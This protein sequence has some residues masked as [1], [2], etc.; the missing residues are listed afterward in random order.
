MARNATGRGA[1]T[2]AQQRYALGAR[3]WRSKIRRIL[4]A[5]LGPFIL[6][7]IAALV[8]YGH[9]LAW[10]G[11]A[12]AGACAATWAAL[13]E[14]PPAYIENW[15]RGAEGE[16]KTAGVV[17]P[18]ERYGLTVLH[19]VDS[20]HG[21]YDHIA[22]GTQGVFVLESK[23]PHG[24]V[25]LRGGVPHLRRQLDPDADTPLKQIRPRA[26]SA[27]AR[28]KQ[29]IEERTGKRTW[30]QAVVVFWAGFPE[31]IVDDGRCVFLHGSRLADWLRARP[32]GLNQG[33]ADSIACAIR[34][35]AD[36]E[37]MESGVASRV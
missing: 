19:D 5:V 9:P 3:R 18:L 23:Y 27:A 13:R 8:V 7:G 34:R 32:N 28:L 10:A 22:F 17:K 16:R 30:V 12:V 14:T 35:I 31:G 24:I 37:T 11:G 6:I 2:Y 15:Q 36:G 33:D 1:G 20:P 29:D 21:N 26:L 25:E 4:A